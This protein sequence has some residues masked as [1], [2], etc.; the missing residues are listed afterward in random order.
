MV[1]KHIFFWRTDIEYYDDCQKPFA[2]GDVD[3]EDRRRDLITIIN[4][5]ICICVYDC[6]Y[7]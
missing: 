7:I 1:L 3:I 2:D 4:A 6:I 5:A